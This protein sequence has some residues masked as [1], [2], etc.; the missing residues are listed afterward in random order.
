MSAC[1]AAPHSLSFH[2]PIGRARQTKAAHASRAGYEQPQR[3]LKPASHPTRQGSGRP[4]AGSC[5]RAAARAIGVGERFAATAT[6]LRPRGSSASDMDGRRQRPG[7]AASW[8]WPSILPLSSVRKAGCRTRCGQRPAQ[9]PPFPPRALQAQ[10]PTLTG[11][12]WRS[13][14]LN[15]AGVAVRGA[16]LPGAGGGCGAG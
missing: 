4:A 12:N 8:L 7:L 9:L 1:A 3:L 13:R 10:P 6:P 5:S 15:A 2:G 11:C 14:R 16:A